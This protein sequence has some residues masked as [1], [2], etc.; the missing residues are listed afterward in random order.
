MIG[1]ETITFSDKT[2]GQFIIDNRL[3]QT[4]VQ[5]DIGTP[6]YKPVTIAGSGV[7]LLTMGIVY[8]LQ[9]SDPQPYSFVGDKIQVSNPAFET[10]DSKIV[11]VGTNQTRWI[12]G[13]GAAVNVPTLSAV[14]TSLDQVPTNVSAILADDQYYYI[15]SSSFPSH[16]ILDGSTVTQTVLDQK[17]LR[18]IRK[19]A[20]RTTETY[21]TPKRDIGIGL[22]GVPFYG[23]KDPESIRYGKLEQIK[24]DLRGTGYVRPPFVLIDQVPNKA[25]AILAGQVVESITVDTADVFPRTPDILIT[26]GRN[27]AVRAVVTGGKV[28]SL[29]LDNPGEFYSSPPEIVIRDNAGRG[30]FAEF[31]AVVNT[32]GQITGFNKIAE[33]NFY[34][35]NT[36]IVDVVP[37]GSGATGIPLLK[38][39][40]FNRYKKIRV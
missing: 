14:A 8:N 32:D 7:T 22:N 39:W 13:T 6:V 30:R 29:I 21:P 5:H 4:A 28:T 35:Q 25:R 20:T 38:E 24:V 31:E 10:S 34:N 12:L 23:Y 26:S 33:G 19:Q 9:P 18:I 36:V 17:L 16:K 27:A 3:A 2:V 1:D 37:V 40:N 15:A 11:N